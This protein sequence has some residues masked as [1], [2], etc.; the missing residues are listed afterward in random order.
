MACGY[1]A[2]A[3]KASGAPPAR[4]REVVMGA[5]SLCTRGMRAASFQFV[6]NL[7]ELGCEFE[8]RLPRVDLGRLFR[9]LQA[10]FRMLAAFFRRRHGHPTFVTSAPTISFR[11]H[12]FPMNRFVPDSLLD[13][14]AHWQERA[15]EA[16]SIAEQ[17]S[18]PDSKQM[19]LR[20]AEDYERAGSA[21]P[22]ADEGVGC[23]KLR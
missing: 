11:S 6:G 2:S 8:Q 5:P 3:A 4:R 1:F 13:N 18:D 7:S 20:I 21:R 22:A 9:E 16:R 15:E 12:R 23:S 17:M 14:P 19:M 10:F